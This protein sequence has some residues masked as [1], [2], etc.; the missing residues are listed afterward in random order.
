MDK[1]LQ[2][3]NEVSFM[4]AHAFISKQALT[5]KSI[6]VWAGFFLLLSWR[7]VVFLSQG[8]CCVVVTG[9]AVSRVKG[10]MQLSAAS[11]L[12]QGSSGMALLC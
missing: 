12:A 8:P 9:A 1:Q 2:N 10:K 11:E 5:L 4:L 6:A 3:V 7:C